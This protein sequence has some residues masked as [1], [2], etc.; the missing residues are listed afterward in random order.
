MAYPQL[1]VTLYQLFSYAL[2]PSCSVSGSY[3][4]ISPLLIFPIHS[5]IN[6]RKHCTASFSASSFLVIIHTF[7]SY[8]SSENGISLS[9]CSFMSSKDKIHRHG[10]AFIFLH[11]LMAQTESTGL[12]CWYP[13]GTRLLHISLW[14]DDKLQTD[15]FQYIAACFSDLQL[16]HFPVHLTDP[17]HLPE[18]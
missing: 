9:P 5:C 8:T 11:H 17:V 4:I 2:S 6:C 7:H 3:R 12:K 1:F 16:S 10:Y 15:C 18:A 13:V 14:S